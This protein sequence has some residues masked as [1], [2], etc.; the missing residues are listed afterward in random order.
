MEEGAGRAL[1]AGYEGLSFKYD[2]NNPP[3]KER[4]DKVKR[5]GLKLQFWTIDN[6]N[7]ILKAIELKPDYIQTDNV[8]Y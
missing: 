4:I 6:K 8:E 2:V 7:D 3:S 5:K 1:K